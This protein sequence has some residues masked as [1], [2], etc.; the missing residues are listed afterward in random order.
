MKNTI[1]IT[2]AN[3]GIGGMI[4]SYLLKQGHRDIVLQYRGESDSI[5]NILNKY[6]V[7]FDDIS[8]KADL[9]HEESVVAL[10]S[11][12]HAKREFVGTVINVAGSSK[13]G[14]SWKTS[15]DDFMSVIQDNLLSAFLCS[16]HFIPGMREKKFGRIVNFSSIVGATGIAGASSYC[17]AKAALVGLTKSMSKELASKNITVNAIALGYFNAGLIDDVSD[18]LKVEIKKNI[19]MQRFGEENDIGSLVQYLIADDSSYFT[20]Q[21]VNLNGG[22]I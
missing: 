18:E 10:A 5:K 11:A 20:G 15:K 3:G 2:G 4:L 19:P 1:L 21:I 13:N 7:N 8:F 14:M 16:K 22:Q 9:C 6:D 17:A 12:I